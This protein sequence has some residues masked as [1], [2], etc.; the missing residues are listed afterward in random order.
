MTAE[1]YHLAASI[2]GVRN[3]TLPAGR[4]LSIGEIGAMV[5]ACQDDETDA[6]RRD[7]AIVAVAYAAGL[8]RA[9]LAGLDVADLQDDGEL[10]TLTIRGK[11]GKTRLGYLDNGAMVA[12]RDWLAI[13]GN[14]PGAVFWSGVR[15]G[16]LI[17]GQRMTSQ[18]IRNVIHRR[19]EQA[20]LDVTSPHDLR[21]S[22]VTHLLDASVDISTV[23]ALAGHASVDTTRR[24]DRRPETAKRKAV[25][26]LHVPYR[27]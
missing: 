9:E 14:A 20:G 18:A 27:K 2:E 11:G 12:T 1:A 22:F 8:R 6:G 24:Y 23:A 26:L 15:G 7:T 19:A 21:R 25:S 4:A 16:R 10:M 17:P 5:R 3:E 13:R